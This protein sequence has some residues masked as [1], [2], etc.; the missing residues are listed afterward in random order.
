MSI[1]V[2]ISVLI[3]GIAYIGY[4]QVDAE[5]VTLNVDGKMVKFAAFEEFLR[6]FYPKPSFEKNN[7]YYKLWTLSL[8]DTVDI[9][10]DE[11]LLK[12][13]RMHDPQYDNDKYTKEWLEGLEN[14]R[15]YFKKIADKRYQLLEK[16]ETF[17]TFLVSN[18]MLGDRCTVILK[19]KDAVMELKNLYQ[20]ILDRYVK[21]MEC[22]VFEDFTRPSIDASIPNLL[23]FLHAG[24]LYNTINVLDALEGNWK[25]G[26]SNILSHVRFGKK[27]VKSSRTLIFN[28][29]SKAIANEALTALANLM[30]QPE[31][32]KELYALILK[33]LPDFT[34]EEY[35]SRIP[36]YGEAFLSADKIVKEKGNLLVQE[37]RT[38]QYVMD[39]FTNLINSEKIPPYRWKTT[40]LESMDVKSDLLWWV[41]NPGGKT[42]FQELIQTEDIKNFYPVVF[43][44]YHLKIKNDLVRISAELHL[45]YV[46]G[47]PA[48]EILKT[49]ATYRSLPDPCTGKPYIWN[50]Q[51]QLLYSIG[52]DK[53]DDGGYMSLKQ[54][55]GTD[56]T[57]PIILFVPP[58]TK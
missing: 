49:L 6:N 9:E 12:Y 7:G 58:A 26:V 27:M 14:E 25:K 5:T 50:S 29:V 53:K 57:I 32:P 4:N 41:R 35:G 46:P 44:S 16:M 28:L 18:D 20:L 31:F 39:F 40:P 30:N 37:N 2:L 55:E 24:R 42:L 43:K 22:N 1:T 19:H 21:L 38:R 48:E 34:Y 54:I 52:L 3:L 10:S 56:F 23:A 36:L 15:A 45:H 13:R 8:A 33:E 11:V 17:D 47:T 51:K